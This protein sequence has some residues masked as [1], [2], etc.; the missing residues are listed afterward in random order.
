METVELIL[1]TWC[2]QY[3]MY[4]FDDNTTR[5]EDASIDN[6]TEGLRFLSADINNAYFT[7][8]NDLYRNIGDTVCVF[9]FTPSK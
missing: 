2:I 9:T 3:L 8:G 4:G 5:E 1:P 6:V 7:H